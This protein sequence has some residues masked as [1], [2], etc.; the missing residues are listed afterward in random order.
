MSRIVPLLP[1]GAVGIARSD[2]DTVVTEHGSAHLRDLGV[3]DRAL[4]LIRIAAPQHRD[5]LQ[6]AW[7]TL[8][9]TL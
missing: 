7:H 1:A 5:A 8:R 2:V 4:A 3:E 9:R 6:S